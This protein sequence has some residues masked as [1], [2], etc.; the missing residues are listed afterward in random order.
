ML[1][2]VKNIKSW[3]YKS[4][5][6]KTYIKNLLK[7]YNTTS[8]D[9]AYTLTTI[10]N[11][12]GYFMTTPIPD[13]KATTVA[14]NI[15][16]EV[17]PKFSFPRILHSDNETE[18]KSTLIGHLAQQ[19]GIRETYISPCHPQS[20][21]KIKNHLTDSSKTVYKT[22]QLMVLWNGTNYS[23]KATTAFNWFPNEDS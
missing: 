15:F 23:H 8:Q 6:L 2:L 7:P 18:F 9:N 16:S 3:L 14:I 12:T 11:L 1:E 13:K 21:R 19:L 4:Q 10:C 17:L 20:N 22:F 5:I